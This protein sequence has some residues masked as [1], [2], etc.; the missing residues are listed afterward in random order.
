MVETQ[1]KLS[2]ENL[3]VCLIFI[4]L[5]IIVF[6]FWQALKVYVPAYES[7]GR[8]WPHIHVRLIGALLLYQVTMLG[9]FGVK[10]FHYTPFVIVLLILSLIFIFVCQKK[11]YRSFQSVPLEVA[12]HELKESPNMEHIFRAYIPPSLSCEKDEEQFEDALSQVSRTTSS[13]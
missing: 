6:V 12:S 8:M 5:F 2:A 7:N 13:V 4:L 3:P 10:K 1:N 9:Y 11:F